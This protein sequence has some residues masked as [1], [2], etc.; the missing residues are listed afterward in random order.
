MHLHNTW[1][2]LCIPIIAYETEDQTDIAE[3]HQHIIL[4]ALMYH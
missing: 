2:Y 3:M 4:L 1:N